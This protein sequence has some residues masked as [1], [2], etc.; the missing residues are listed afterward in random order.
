MSDNEETFGINTTSK[1]KL[2][3]SEIHIVHQQIL[4]KARFLYN[5]K[6][7]NKDAN[8]SGV[9]RVKQMGTYLIKQIYENKIIEFADEVL[10]NQKYEYLVPAVFAY[11]SCDEVLTKASCFYEH[12]IRNAKSSC[13]LDILVPFLKS[14]A[15]FRFVESL[16]ISIVTKG[17]F[18]KNS[19]IKEI[20][21]N[22]LLLP[23]QILHVLSCLL[24]SEWSFN[25]IGNILLIKFIFP[26]VQQF[27]YHIGAP[28]LINQIK[29][30]I[31]EICNSKEEIFNLIAK[32]RISI[33]RIVDYQSSKYFD[34]I[35][36]TSEIY[37]L[38]KL[39]ESIGEL[40]NII[41]FSDLSII[42]Q[43]LHDQP[44]FVRYYPRKSSQDMNEALLGF[45]NE[46]DNVFS[47]MMLKKDFISIL[48]SVQ[49]Q[50][51]WFLSFIMKKEERP[52]LKNHY[53]KSFQYLSEISTKYQDT[54]DKWRYAVEDLDNEW[55]KLFEFTDKTE[56][57][58]LIIKDSIK[59]VIKSL[60]NMMST[61]D[62]KTLYDAFN[63]LMYVAQQVD[64]LSPDD[65]ERKT[66]FKYI[67]QNCKAK[68]FMTIFT[69]L[70]AYAVWRPTF[71]QLLPVEQASLWLKLD[72]AV[73]D[74]LAQDDLF[75]KAYIQI[76][77]QL[78]SA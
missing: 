78:D 24:K 15:S 28:D 40:P 2:E 64:L 25:V 22:L 34:M 36:T 16:V 7:M 66:L 20:E 68:K 65:P 59:P 70:N 69:Q 57:D 52:K 6:E 58:S 23:S 10:N 46:L 75:L 45:N 12:I 29:E 41:K 13:Q 72:S 54:I 76:A 9:A 21:N 47:A 51:Q 48:E 67:F 44:F 71:F 4:V 73:L 33:P 60:V 18:T 56:S 30:S 32:S 35:L 74:C 63:S 61:I 38:T 19:I 39:L 27:L 77:E 8:F 55:I 1:L 5:M 50:F 62:T 17:K 37:D 11:F 31:E 42:G 49:T 53:I 26:F 3:G 14:I 43:H